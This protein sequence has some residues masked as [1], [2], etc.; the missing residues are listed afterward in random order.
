[1]ERGRGRGRGR[2][3]S[4]SKVREGGR[5]GRGEQ[6]ERHGCDGASGS[7]SGVAGTN[8]NISR[9][10]TSAK[11]AVTLTSP[12]PPN[13]QN[14]GAA[15]SEVAAPT[16]DEL[17]LQQDALKEEVEESGLWPMSS[18]HVGTETEEGSG[19]KGI[20]AEAEGVAAPAIVHDCMLAT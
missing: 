20:D 2:G 19:S 14:P 8:V 13:T 7:S 12:D 18:G 9:S 5:K 16:S 6:R 17:S 1:M 11:P 15:S 4:R 3:R 10:T